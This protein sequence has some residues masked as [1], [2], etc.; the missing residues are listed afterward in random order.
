MTRVSVEATPNPLVK[1]FSLGVTLVKTPFDAT[2]LAMDVPGLAR[3]L[4]AGAVSIFVGQ[5]YLA[6]GVADA[7]EWAT[8]LAPVR[9]AIADNADALVAFA[10]ARDQDAVDAVTNDPVVARIINL[11]DNKIR[12]AVAHD[13]GDVRF[14]AF[15][16][17]V[18]ELEMAGACSGCPSSAATLKLGVLNMMRYFVP[19]VRDVVSVN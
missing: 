18:L 4:E 16:D 8:L 1:K 19:E 6:V 13:G 10:A 15:R 11:L 7:H 2:E 14:R 17:G 12:P 5:D 3:L 9:E